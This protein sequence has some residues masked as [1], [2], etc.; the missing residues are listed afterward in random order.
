MSITILLAY[1]LQSDY[2][3]YRAILVSGMPR[4]INFKKKSI[5]I[6]GSDVH[7]PMNDPNSHR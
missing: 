3:M 7:S 6:L 1:L 4:E 5:L 2:R